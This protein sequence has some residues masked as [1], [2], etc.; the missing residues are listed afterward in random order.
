M[1]T[2]TVK[3][4]PNLA[5]RLETLVRRRKLKKSALVREAIERLVSEDSRPTQGSFLEL[6]ADLAGIYEGPKDLSSNPKH[7]RGYGKK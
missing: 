5:A 2:L 6:A 1:A 3:L 7:M 4:P